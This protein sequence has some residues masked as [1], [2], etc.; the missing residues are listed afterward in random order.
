MI[1][2]NPRRHCPSPCAS[3]GATL[4]PAATDAT[5]VVQRRYAECVRIF[6]FVCPA[7]SSDSR[8]VERYRPGVAGAS[9][10]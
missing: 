10:G 4:G 9:S 3:P 7:F 5:S 8:A 2:A 1:R 6:G